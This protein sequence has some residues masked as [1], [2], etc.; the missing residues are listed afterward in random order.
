MRPRRITTGK[1]A[2]LLR[3][4]NPFITDDMVRAWVEAGRVIAYRNPGSEQGWYYLD[5]EDLP[6]F[7]IEDL[8]LED[9]VIQLVINALGLNVMQ[10]KF[11]VIDNGP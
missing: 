10:L 4:Q 7:L 3:K 8:K 1:L 6:R 2:K 5:P 9:E 11:E